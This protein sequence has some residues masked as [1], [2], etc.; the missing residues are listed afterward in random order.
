MKFI[1]FTHSLLHTLYSTPL[2]IIPIMSGWIEAPEEEEFH[3]LEEAEAYIYQH[4]FNKGYGLSRGHKRWDK[5]KPPQLRRWDF[6]CDKGGEVRGKGTERQ[7]GS[8]KTYCDFEVRISRK[9]TGGFEVKVYRPYH[10]HPASDDH[11]QHS[12]YRRPT[13]EQ[14]QRIE[15][16]SKSGVAPRF[17][18]NELLE[19][20]PDTLITTQEIYNHKHKMR[21]ERLNGNTWIEVLVEELKEDENW[22]LQYC[23]TQN[24]MVNFLFFARDEMIDIAQASPSV[25]IVDATYHTNKLN[26]PAVHFQAITL[27]RKTASIALA[28]IMNKEE[29]SYLIACRAFRELVMGDARIEVLL[30]DD[31]TA[32]KNALTAIYPTVPQL[33]CLWHINKNVLTRAKKTFATHPEFSAE[34]N[35]R[36]KKYR[37]EFMGDWDALCYTRTEEEFDERYAAFREKYG[38]LPLLIQ[39]IHEEKYPKRKQF[40]KPWTSQVRHFG[41]TVTSRGESGHS[42]YKGWLLHNRHD[43]LDI[44]DRW[45][46]MTRTF[47]TD[48]R[49]ELATE[50]DRITHELRVTRWNPKEF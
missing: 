10:N 3:T 5:K 17:I 42:Q 30:I 32:L 4:A 41:H 44:K 35:Q 7:T 8:K 49:K 27:I 39:Y 15:S 36:N 38:Y 34:T 43:L 47:L 26:L 18:L 46:S 2:V 22:A 19:M 6:N 33:L 24:C 50:R 14:M 21:K 28:F 29:P 31:E 37:E 9:L 13:D 12:Q 11:R 20:D 25:I 48:Y 45:A 23:T 16:L 40:T 1:K